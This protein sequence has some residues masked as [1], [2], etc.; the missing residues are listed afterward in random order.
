MM[1]VDPIVLRERISG[2]EAEIVFVVPDDL[3]YFDG[4]F[5]GVRV[6]PG[7]VQIRW[8]IETARR[9][10]PVAGAFA[11]MEAVKFQQIMGPGIEVTLALKYASDTGK[12]YFSFDSEQGRYSSGRVILSRSAR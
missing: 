6:V 12:L 4:H 11:G 8:A 10:L 5:P 9:C 2:S 1:V 7:V 3:E